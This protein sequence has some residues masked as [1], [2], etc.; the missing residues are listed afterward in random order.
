MRA[1]GLVLRHISAGRAG[2]SGCQRRAW[3]ADGMMAGRV[4]RRRFKTRTGPSKAVDE[5][6][7]VE[8]RQADELERQARAEER[9][10]YGSAGVRRASKL[11]DV[12]R[13]AARLV[14]ERD[15][16]VEGGERR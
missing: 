1:R 2:G 5:V 10:L 11:S 15:V 12:E 7:I 13:Q 4:A 14:R 9:R 8:L 3:A 6:K 16:G